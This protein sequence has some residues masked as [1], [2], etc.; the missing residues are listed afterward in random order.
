M[1]CS[2]VGEARATFALR[3]FDSSRA[4]RRADS[5]TVKS[6]RE[7]LFRAK[8]D[9]RNEHPILEK[10]HVTTD[11]G[12]SAVKSKRGFD[13]RAWSDGTLLRLAHA[14]HRRRVLAAE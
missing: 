8:L 10:R 2:E 4:A 1:R 9:V 6:H 13:S 12:A 5:R 11:A 3:T 14:A 7:A